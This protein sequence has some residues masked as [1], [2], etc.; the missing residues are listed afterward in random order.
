MAFLHDVRRAERGEVW[1]AA[2]GKGVAV[3]EKDQAE[4]GASPL[5][6]WRVYTPSHP[7]GVA[8][9]LVLL[10]TNEKGT[11][12]LAYNMRLGPSSEIGVVN[13]EEEPEKR[14][15]RNLGAAVNFIAL[16]SPQSESI[17]TK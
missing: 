4:P 9:R 1:C 17:G 3:L 8:A 7:M 6:N 13:L 5:E 15:Y 12:F 16:R 14:R 10:E 11:P 2:D